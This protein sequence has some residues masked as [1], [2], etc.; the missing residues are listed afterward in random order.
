[1][2]EAQL[3]L[4]MSLPYAPV[5]PKVEPCSPRVVA[6][7]GALQRLV[8]GNQG[9]MPKTGLPITSAYGAS[10]AKH[11]DVRGCMH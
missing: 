10:P 4:A 5:S 3:G 1:M 2:S 9:S 7:L 8:V 11:A 6:R